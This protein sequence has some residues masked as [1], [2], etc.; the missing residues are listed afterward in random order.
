M[1][2]NKANEKIV[3]KTIFHFFWPRRHVEINFITKK[4]TTCSFPFLLSKEVDASGDNEEEEEP[5]VEKGSEGFD[6][7]IVS[8]IL[9]FPNCQQQ[10]SLLCV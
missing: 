9:S 5:A 7:I 8:E 2:N 4:K 6:F 1:K 10:P 3:D